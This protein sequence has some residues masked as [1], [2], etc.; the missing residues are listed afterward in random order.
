M[1]RWE[2]RGLQEASCAPGMLLTAMLTGRE[3]AKVLGR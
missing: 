2:G 1:K 3:D